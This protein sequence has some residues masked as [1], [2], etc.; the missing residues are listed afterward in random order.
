[1]AEDEIDKQF[2]K[3]RISAI[4]MSYDIEREPERRCAEAVLASM[5]TPSKTAAKSYLAAARW[6]AM[7]TKRR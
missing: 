7:A 4:E 1:M 5:H 2:V 3:T 6:F